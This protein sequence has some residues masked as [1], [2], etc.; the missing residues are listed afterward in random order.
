MPY[1][2]KLLAMADGRPV[3]FCAGAYVKAYDVDAYGG[4]GRLIPTQ[5]RASAQP[6]ET[7]AQAIEFVQRQSTVKPLREDGEPNRPLTAYTVEISPQ[8]AP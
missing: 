3:R 1:V 8:E 2:I 7:P 4:R 6:F 5:E